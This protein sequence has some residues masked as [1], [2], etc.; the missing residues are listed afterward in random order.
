MFSRQVSVLC[1]A[2]VIFRGGRRFVFYMSSL[3][4]PR[5]AT[6]S[7]TLVAVKFLSEVHSEPISLFT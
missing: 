1:A 6:D 2:P 7:V 3:P 5:D 4:G